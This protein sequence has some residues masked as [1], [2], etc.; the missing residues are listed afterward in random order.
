MLGFITKL[1]WRLRALKLRRDTARLAK[2]RQEVFD[3]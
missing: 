3:E 2:L 1:Y